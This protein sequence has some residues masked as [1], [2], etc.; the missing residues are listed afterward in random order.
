MKKIVFLL[1]AVLWIVSCKHDD[2]PANDPSLR[3][4]KV[5]GYVADNLNSRQS[6]AVSLTGKPGE[7]KTVTAG[8]NGDFNFTGVA[9]GD[10]TVKVTKEGY[11][12]ESRNITVNKDTDIGVL[13]ITIKPSEIITKQ[14]TLDFGES[15]NSLTLSFQILSYLD[16]DWSIMHN[17]PW[18]Q[19]IEPASGKHVY[20]EKEKTPPTITVSVQ[21]DRER[22]V[23]GKNDD[24]IQITTSSNGGADIIIV[25]YSTTRTAVPAEVIVSAATGIGASFATLNATITNSGLPGYSERGFCYNKTGNPTIFDMKQDVPSTDTE[26]YLLNIE[27]LDY[28]TTYFVKAYVIQNGTPVYSEKVINFTTTWTDAKVSTLS[29]DNVTASSATLRGSVTNAGDPAYSER[30]F[31]YNKTGNPTISNK[32][33]V[34]GSGAGDYTKDISNLDYKTT[35]YVCAYVLQDGKPIYGATEIFSTIWIETDITTYAATGIEANACTLNGYLNHMGQPQCSEYGFV[36]SATQTNPTTA[37][38][39]ITLTGYATAYSV[40][41]TEGIQENQTYYVR[42]YAIQPGE[43]NPVYGAVTR[44]TTGTPP[45]VHTLPATDVTRINF[46][47]GK[48]SL[49]ASLN[50]NVTNAGDPAYVQRG[51][52][53]KVEDL[54]WGTP[55]TYEWDRVETVPTTGTGAYSTITHELNHMEWYVVRAFVKTASG[56]VYYGGAVTFNTWNYTEY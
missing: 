4:Y 33:V 30:G 31:C 32:V 44:F 23:A 55:P 42:T 24:K 38:T 3:T 40:N 47:D 19:K 15:H 37:D 34:A 11:E 27:N 18:I 45:V 48:W 41:V 6:A 52:V 39:K 51:F 56:K 36:Y 25:A 26:S 28:Q 13:R 35:Y 53:Y 17:C 5:T 12:G 43:P 1:I 50:G 54:L 8:N 7:S 22:L 29:P 49:F 10:Y 46:I 9:Q 20:N 14:D 2:D 21:I 16:D